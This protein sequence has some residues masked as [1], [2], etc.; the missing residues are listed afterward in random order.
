MNKCDSVNAI[1][2]VRYDMKKY[3]ENL[4]I[5]SVKRQYVSTRINEILLETGKM[6]QLYNLIE[7]HFYGEWQYKTLTSTSR[8]HERWTWN[9]IIAMETKIT[10]CNEGKNL[11]IRLKLEKKL[12]S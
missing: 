11:W 8:L 5:I 2:V 12:L 3:T 10:L 7:Y 1:D 6:T 9:K 4:P